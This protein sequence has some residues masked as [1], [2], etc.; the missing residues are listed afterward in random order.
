[1]QSHLTSS[2]DDDDNASWYTVCQ[3]PMVEWRL[4]CENCR[5][6]TVVGLRDTGPCTLAGSR[7][8]IGQPDVAD[9]VLSQATTK[10]SVRRK[11]KIERNVICRRGREGE[12]GGW[13]GE[14]LGWAEPV[15]K[16]V[17][18]RSSVE[19]GVLTLLILFS[20]QR[21][22]VVCWLLNVPAPG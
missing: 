17:D 6:L 7:S 8:K 15:S 22:L 20:L 5:H 3:V 9:R 1:M 21:R 19:L 18:Q 14:G 12:E 10:G 2:F 13:G 4:D 11:T 16:E